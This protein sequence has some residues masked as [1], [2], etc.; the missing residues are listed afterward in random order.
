MFLFLV[1]HSFEN[2][3][4]TPNM[5]LCSFH[6]GYKNRKLYLG[7]Q[8]DGTEVSGENPKGRR[9]IARATMHRCT[10]VCILEAPTVSRSAVL[11]PIPLVL[12]PHSSTLNLAVES[13]LDQD[14]KTRIQSIP[15]ATAHPGIPLTTGKHTITSHPPQ[16]SP[17]SWERVTF[18]RLCLFCPQPLSVPE[19]MSPSCCQLDQA[20]TGG[21]CLSTL[22]RLR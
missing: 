10:Q 19:P 9:R 5:I 8:T 18:P 21:L 13:S 6:V 22:P 11:L 16:F 20:C 12:T 3:L 7:M 14:F 1:L 17:A 4:S 2:S 15:A